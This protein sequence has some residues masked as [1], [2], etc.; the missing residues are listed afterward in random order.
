MLKLIAVLSVLKAITRCSSAISGN[1]SLGVS[2]S[3][4][5]YLLMYRKYN[6]QSSVSIMIEVCQLV[7]W[8]IVTSWRVCLPPSYCKFFQL[9]GPSKKLSIF[10]CSLVPLVLRNYSGCS[11]FLLVLSCACSSK[12]KA[13]SKV[14]MCFWVFD[15]AGSGMKMRWSLHTRPVLAEYCTLYLYQNWLLRTSST[16]KAL[17]PGTVQSVPDSSAILFK[18]KFF[19]ECRVWLFP[20]DS[21]LDQYKWFIS[22]YV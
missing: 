16:T 3:V 7:P 15:L 17:W 13:C 6:T 14:A 2:S 1:M 5:M 20:G 9:S 18:F 8:T 22:Y 21:T 10:G 19:H 11:Y 12:F 4:S